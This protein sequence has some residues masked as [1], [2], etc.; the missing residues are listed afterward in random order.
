M[1]LARWVTI[2]QLK[3]TQFATQWVEGGF[4]EL[5]PEDM[6]PGEWDEHYSVWAEGQD[7]ENKFGGRLE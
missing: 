3:I 5:N 1:K 7:H 4:S 2:E 6:S